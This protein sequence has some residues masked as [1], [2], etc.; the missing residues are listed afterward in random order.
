MAGSLRDGR[1]GVTVVTVVTI[2]A[3]LRWIPVFDHNVGTK[4]RFE[5]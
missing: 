5:V 4:E 1:D 2:F 3:R